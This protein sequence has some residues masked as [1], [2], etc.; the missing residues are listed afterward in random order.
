MNESST[1][2]R[3]YNKETKKTMVV[4]ET[5]IT[6]M[7]MQQRSLKYFTMMIV[8]LLMNDFEYIYF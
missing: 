2:L 5:P 7:S 6:I 3:K 4:V 8:I 1:I